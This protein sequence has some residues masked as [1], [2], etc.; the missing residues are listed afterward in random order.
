LGELEAL[1]QAVQTKA[2][3]TIVFSRRSGADALW[4]ASA[5]SRRAH[6]IPGVTVARDPD[7]AEA[8]HFG[9]K[10][11]GFT[12]LYSADGKLL[13]RGGITDGRGHSGDNIGRRAVATLLKGERAETSAT[14]VFGCPL[15]AA[16]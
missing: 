4:D 15:F 2:A 7:G 1:L 11:S 10:T 3:V 12:L 5:L 9:A 13:F 8:R 6:L 14:H 16:Q